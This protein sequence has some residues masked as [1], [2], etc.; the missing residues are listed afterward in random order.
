MGKKRRIIALLALEVTFFVGLAAVVIFFW[1]RQVQ[2]RARA[3]F[4]AEIGALD[5]KAHV[6]AEVPADRNGADLW[7][8]AAEAIQ[9]IPEDDP[10]IRRLGDGRPWTPELLVEAEGLLERY[11]RALDLAAPARRAEGSNFHLD[12]SSPQ[13]AAL[14][15]GLLPLS[16]LL[17]IQ[18]RAALRGTG[19]LA[20]AADAAESLDAL[21]RAMAAEPLMIYQL[22]R[23]AISGRHLDL[24][25]ELLSRPDL[26]LQT[27]ERLQRGLGAEL[28]DGAYFD[29][30]AVEAA[31]YRRILGVGG[32]SSETSPLGRL[33]LA[34][35]RPFDEAA[36]L[37][38]YQA[39]GEA[40]REPIADVY[41]YTKEAMDRP[42]VFAPAADML[43][44]NLAE[45]PVRHR[46]R[47]AGRR[48]ARLA[49]AARGSHLT[50]GTYPARPMDLGLD[51][52]NLE[53]PLAGGELTWTLGDDGSLTFAFPDAAEFWEDR[54]EG[55]HY[56][57]PPLAW[58]LPSS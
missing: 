53:D 57:A 55:S 18:G 11:E 8:E 19:D 5:P 33:T 2:D 31:P 46:L 32:E 7:L 13:T 50:D 9:W 49:V 41:G 4:E 45:L 54:S 37:S 35:S 15:T 39:I 6:P 47:I 34:L 23:L 16:R 1:G 12:Y 42:L 48:L 27:L 43:I 3:E 22:I 28:D 21:G 24:V 36:M 40:S 10:R 38:L 56:P 44:P 17:H 14:N 30:L 29:A 25:E 52:D 20:A 58:R 26:D 51:G